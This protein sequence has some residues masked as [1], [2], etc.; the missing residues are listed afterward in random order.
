MELMMH[1]W[2]TGYF[3][4]KMP[5]IL[6]HHDPGVGKT[7]T[8][9]DAMKQTG[10]SY[11]VIVPAFLTQNW[12]NELRMWWPECSVSVEGFKG[13]PADIN[14]RVI[15]T[16]YDRAQKVDGS[17]RLRRAV[18]CDEAH[19][20]GGQSKRA[21]YMMGVA[22]KYQLKHLILMTGTPMSNRIGELY[23]LL[24]MLDCVDPKGF[25]KIY[26]RSK[27]FLEAFCEYREFRLPGK[28]WPIREY[29]G[30]KSAGILRAWTGLWFSRFRMEEV[31]ELPDLVEERIEVEGI[32]DKIN[33]ALAKEWEKSA[34]GIV[35]EAGH[36]FGTQVGEHISS[37]KAA[38]ATAKVA[39][40]CELCAGLERPFVVFSDHV[41]AAK[42]IYRILNKRD[43]N[44]KCS[45]CLVTGE[46]SLGL[47]ASFVDQF[48]R[49][50][51]DI[52]VGTIGSCGVG[53][54]LTKA[55]TVVVNDYS[56]IPAKN[57]QAIARVHR[58]G[59]QN[60][61]IVYTVLGGRIDTKI[62]SKIREK[63][64]IIKEMS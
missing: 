11:V 18:V 38:A 13:K 52:F 1:Q 35:P 21:E 2:L 5:A 24:Y 7:A 19:Y 16:S 48:Q 34:N 22:L 29:F 62:F 14:A 10:H 25:R 20:L 30:L 44:G 63:M 4:A 27:K 59:Q 9:I 36:E 15:L 55:R 46:T 17:I 8:V 51:F 40:T 47:R 23:N 6:L 57:E 50:E 12:V 56:W 42:D 31:L 39:A 26:G 45:A 61:V 3:A 33:A 49:G 64:K 43:D 37:A 54:N 32:N 28:Q 60:K 58:F 53:I 41:Q